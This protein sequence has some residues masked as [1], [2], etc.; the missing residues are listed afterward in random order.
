M[1]LILPERYAV[2]PP[3]EFWF[4]RPGH[5]VPI[6]EV[7]SVKRAEELEAKGWELISIGPMDAEPAPAPQA[8][9]YVEPEFDDAGALASGQQE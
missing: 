3:Q 8:E 7:V 1:T 9:F 2:D 6:Q 4:R 5:D